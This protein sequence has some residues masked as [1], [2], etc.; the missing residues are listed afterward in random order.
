MT[1]SWRDA[2]RKSPYLLKTQPSCHYGCPYWPLFYKANYI[3]IQMAY[4]NETEW[5]V[6]PWKIMHRM[7]CFTHLLARHL[8]NVSCFM[9]EAIRDA[10][11]TIHR[12]QAA[13]PPPLHHCIIM[14]VVQHRI[15]V[16]HILSYHY[17]SLLVHICM[18]TPCWPCYHLEN[19]SHTRYWKFPRPQ[20]AT[21]WNFYIFC[22]KI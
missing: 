9:S 4:G 7:D 2:V 21:P 19:I 18:P 8:S 12:R 11:Q 1:S 17:Y 13:P 6:R 14:A 22:V 5:L 10:E 16:Y 3:P 15:P 20:N